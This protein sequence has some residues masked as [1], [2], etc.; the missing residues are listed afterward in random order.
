VTLA[1][2]IAPSLGDGHPTRPIPDGVPG[3]AQLSD[4]DIEWDVLVDLT[5]AD[6][7]IKT[8]TEALTAGKGVVLGTTGI[9]HADIEKLG[10][11]AEE[12]GV[13]LLYVPNFSIGA[14]LMMRFA[15]EAAT[16]LKT[17]EIVEIHHETK[18]DSPSGT[19]R[20]TAELV[21][22]SGAT[23]SPA[24]EA[25][26]GLEIDGVRVHSLRIPGATAHQ[27][28]VLGA[29]G[30]ILTIRHDAI[31]RGCYAAGV[32]LAV[33]GVNDTPGLRIGLEQVL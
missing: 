11:I 22:A 16:H 12:K 15:A 30:E 4:V 9:T 14:V 5:R 24:D 19:A 33:C 25:S 13:G 2:C 20:R 8:V 32:A 31:D 23:S 1:G 26:R 7:A 10:A 3:F 29:P 27:E 17:A 18:L 21:A 28:V 6:V